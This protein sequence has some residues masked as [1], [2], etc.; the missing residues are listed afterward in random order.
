MVPI[1]LT[2][3]STN[4]C[5]TEGHNICS[6]HHSG[7]EI[8]WNNAVEINDITKFGMIANLV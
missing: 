8:T 5:I 1:R 7:M 3:K 4:I 2:T 6:T